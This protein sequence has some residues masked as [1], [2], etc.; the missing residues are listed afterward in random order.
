MSEK[1][2]IKKIGEMNEASEIDQVLSKVDN[3]IIQD[4]SFCL[5]A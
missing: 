5:Y 2:R 4:V 3:S 1:N